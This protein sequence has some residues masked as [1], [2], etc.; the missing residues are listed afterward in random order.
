MVGLETVGRWLFIVG[1]VLVVMGGLIWLLARIFPGINQFPGTIRVQAGG[2]T[3][4]FP[5]L[6]S[7]ILSIVLTVVLNLILRAFNR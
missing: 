2:I 1:T 5:V 4:L 6:A 3:C 7:I